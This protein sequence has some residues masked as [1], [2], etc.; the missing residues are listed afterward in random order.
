LNWIMKGC[1]VILSVI[2]IPF[3]HEV[4]LKDAHAQGLGITLMVMQSILSLALI[5]M[6]VMKLGWGKLWFKKKNPAFVRRSKAG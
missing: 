4:K 3:A 2:V 6:T 5:I 1:T